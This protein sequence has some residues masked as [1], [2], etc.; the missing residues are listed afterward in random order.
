MM[1]RPIPTDR[2]L[3]CAHM[4]AGWRGGISG[5]LPPVVSVVSHTQKKLDGSLP[6]ACKVFNGGNLWP[7]AMRTLKNTFN[8]VEVQFDFPKASL[9]FLW[10]F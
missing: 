3:Q 2:H 4:D 8:F 10:G 7:G 5:G 6:A 9:L 1:S